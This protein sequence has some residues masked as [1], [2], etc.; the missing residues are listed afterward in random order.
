MC[1]PAA[2][3]GRTPLSSSVL[4]GTSNWGWADSATFHQGRCSIWQLVE[5]TGKQERSNVC[6]P[7]TPHRLMAS[8]GSLPPKHRCDALRAL[9]PFFNNIRFLFPE[10]GFEFAFLFSSFRPNAT[11]LQLGLREGSC[12][13]CHELLSPTWALEPFRLGGTKYLLMHSLAWNVWSDLGLPYGN[14][15]RFLPTAAHPDS[16]VC[17]LGAAPPVP[18][19]LG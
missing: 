3:L 16:A 2:Q 10:W 14:P 1:A 7:A 19:G 12:L 8:R 15:H 6:A 13:S 17:C 4:P 18:S 5:G 9:R 11:T